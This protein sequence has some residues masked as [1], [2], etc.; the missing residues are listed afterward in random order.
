[1]NGA[2]SSNLGKKVVWVLGAGFSRPV[3]GPLLDDLFRFETVDTLGALY[4]DR[5]INLRHVVRAYVSGNRE[6]AVPPATLSVVQ[7]QRW[8]NV[9]EFIEYVDR[10]ATRSGT[11]EAS[12][13]PRLMKRAGIP[14]GYT[15]DWLLQHAQL[16]MA[17]ECSLFL[18]GVNLDDEK[19]LPYKHWTDNLEPID[20]VITFNY[21][22]VLERLKAKWG[23]LL[24][25]M[26]GPRPA[27]SLRVQ[28]HVFKLHGSTNWILK[29]AETVEIDNSGEPIVARSPNKLAIATP[30]P[31]KAGIVNRL[32]D[33][34]WGEAEYELANADAI[35]FVGYRFP[36]TDAEA[37]SRILG[38][39]KK[40]RK[41]PRL[42]TV[43]GKDTSNPD[44]RRLVALL[45]MTG[46][47]NVEPWPMF[48]QDFLDQ[49]ER[50]MLF[51]RAQDGAS[52]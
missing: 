1:M 35:I 29:D 24:V 51:E 18:N 7:T 32:F 11:A 21:D 9:E 36:E 49:F 22:E 26:P 25:Q 45:K 42:H 50:E 48:A 40:N 52:G 43:L 14:G 4:E 3:G 15:P 2:P 30:G 12:M 38:A 23:K 6:I 34:L 16:L 46:H 47:D 44:T 28:A 13:L 8:R 17:A 37:R 27:T 41:R 20:S 10:G 39:I 33:G 31:T 5:A 19:W